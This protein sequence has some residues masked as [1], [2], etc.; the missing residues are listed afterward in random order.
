MRVFTYLEWYSSGSDFSNLF[1]TTY[2]YG[3]M[4][5]GRILY[6]NGCTTVVFLILIWYFNATWPLQ[7][8]NVR[9][10]YFPLYPLLG[11]FV[12]VNA[13]EDINEIEKTKEK[14]SQKYFEETFERNKIKVSI[15]NLH[16]VFG[17]KKVLTNINLNLYE[18][19]LTAL[20]GRF[21]YSPFLF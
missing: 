7:Y 20:L 8:G 11:L 5:I 2:Q 18:N 21:C 4:S 19:Q 10:W 13:E 14:S 3:P 17:K 1:E 16:K 6:V 12:S 15:K 9:P